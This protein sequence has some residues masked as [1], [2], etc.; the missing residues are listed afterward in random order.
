MSGPGSPSST[1]RTAALGIATGGVLLGHRLAY[2]IAGPRDARVVA[3][4]VDGHGYLGLANE[5][6]LTLAIAGVAAVFLGRLTRDDQMRMPWRVTGVRL[7]AFQIGVFTAIKILERLSVGA[8]VRDLVA[9]LTVGVVV[10]GLLASIGAL[11]IAWLLRAAAS[12]EAAVGA[13]AVISPPASAAFA[14]VLAHPT[15]HAA[16]ATVGSRGPPHGG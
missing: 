12:V 9:M 11:L 6:A 1:P 16:P 10:Q 2:A 5:L 8:P 7:A 15:H 4:A 3:G 13:A 14:I